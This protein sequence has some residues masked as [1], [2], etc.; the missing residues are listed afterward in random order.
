VPSGAV[1]LAIIV[2]YSL[3]LLTASIH[4]Q[5][6]YSGAGTVSSPLFRGKDVLVMFL[7]LRF[8]FI[9]RRPPL[10][11]RTTHLYVRRPEGHG[12]GDIGSIRLPAVWANCSHRSS[13]KRAACRR[14]I[15]DVIVT[16]GW[17][18]TLT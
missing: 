2:E 10:F 16:C 14:N 4:G 13:S 1:L 8:N 12:D 17:N 6:V 5:G 11:L 9:S 3:D 15:D 18:Y 7:I